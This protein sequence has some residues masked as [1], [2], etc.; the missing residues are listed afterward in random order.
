MMNT[1]A[2]STFSEMVRVMQDAGVDHDTQNVIARM[3]ASMLVDEWSRGLRQGLN[4]E[5]E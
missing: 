3:V 2:D 4:K 1:K 5:S